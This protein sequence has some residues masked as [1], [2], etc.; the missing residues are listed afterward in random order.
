MLFYLLNQ[1][2]KP[3]YSSIKLDLIEPTQ[4]PAP[5]NRQTIDKNLSIL[6]VNQLRPNSLQGKSKAILLYFETTLR[7]AIIKLAGVM[8][9]NEKPCSIPTWLENGD[10][11]D[12]D[13][14]KFKFC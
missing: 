12:L 7:W 2:V 9:L 10:V 1:P 3:V 6:Q 8:L 11:I 14:L 4:M 5:F 13:G